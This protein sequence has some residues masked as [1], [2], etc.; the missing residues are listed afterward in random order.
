[1]IQTRNEVAGI[2]E[3]LK[4]LANRKFP[5]KSS[6]CIARNLQLLNKINLETEENRI[7]ACKSFAKQDDKGEPCLDENGNFVIED[8]ELFNAEIKKLYAENVEVNFFHYSENLEGCEIEPFLI[9][10]LLDKIIV[11]EF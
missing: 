10:P 2:L 6:Y 1:M 9:T 3:V 5:S 8:T 4:I 11:N 7:T